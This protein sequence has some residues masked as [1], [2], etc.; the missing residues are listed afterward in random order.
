[1]GM[2]LY[3]W[4]RRKICAKIW[5]VTW[6]IWED[7]IKMILKEIKWVRELDVFGSGQGKHFEM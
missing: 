7:N 4:G 5:Q 1:M 2:V 3:I 6:P